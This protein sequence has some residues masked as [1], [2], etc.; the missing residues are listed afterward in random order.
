MAFANRKEADRFL[1]GI[2][3]RYQLCQRWCGLHKRDGACFHYHLKTCLGACV[4]EE[5]AGTYNSRVA[6]ALRT[7]YFDHPDFLM[8][9]PGRDPG[10][11]AV[12]AIREGHYRGFGFVEEMI[13]E[14]GDMAAV[15]A[16]IT[17]RVDNADIRRIINTYRRQ[18][19][20]LD[21]RVL[22]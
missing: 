4:G 11:V 20:D 15:Q 6:E 22:P 14:R 12:V 10:E 18:H 2:V 16:A 13:L 17:P 9:E 7:F 1:H 5:P 21:I 8:V 19:P 3:E